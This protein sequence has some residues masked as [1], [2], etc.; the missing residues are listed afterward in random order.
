MQTVLLSML[1]L[2]PPSAPSSLGYRIVDVQNRG[3]YPFNHGTG[4]GNLLTPDGKLQGFAFVFHSCEPF[5]RTIG[6]G[7]GVASLGNG[8]RDLWIRTTS[9]ETGKPHEC[10]LRVSPMNFTYYEEG[11]E[12]KTSPLK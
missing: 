4:H 1:L 8:P 6:P 12:L 5:Q 2:F 3:L 11:G 10:Q 7:F 9:V